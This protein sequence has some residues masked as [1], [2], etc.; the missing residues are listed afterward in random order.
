MIG[1]WEF[2]VLGFLAFAWAVSNLFMPRP[3]RIREEY[4]RILRDAYAPIVREIL[5]R[6]DRPKGES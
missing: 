2:S 3:S 1:L 6:S 4:D 5:E